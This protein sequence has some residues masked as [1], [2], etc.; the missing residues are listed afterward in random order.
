MHAFKC[1]SHQINAFELLDFHN[2]ENANLNIKKI[3]FSVYTKGRPDF[4]APLP[5]YYCI[6]GEAKSIFL[7]FAYSRQ[8]LLHQKM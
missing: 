6:I 4:G 2:W 3:I 1:I 5:L 7:H 8:N